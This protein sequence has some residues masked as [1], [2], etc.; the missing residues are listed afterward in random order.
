MAQSKW[1]ESPLYFLLCPESASPS[2]D[3]SEHGLCSRN[4]RSGVTLVT[5]TSLL[6]HTVPSGITMGELLWL[7][8]TSWGLK[9][10][11]LSKCWQ[12]LNADQ[13]LRAM[14]CCILKTSKGFLAFPRPLW[15]YAPV[16]NYLGSGIFFSPSWNL[17]FNSQPLSL[18]LQWRA[19]LCLLDNLLIDIGKLLWGPPKTYLL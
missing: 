15:V 6:F 18:V 3:A 17:W 4:S 8:G 5:K 1:R 16:F 2:S 12:M 13:M 19:C 14:F 7:E 10:S 11:F 9:P